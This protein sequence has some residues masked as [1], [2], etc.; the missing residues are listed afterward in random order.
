MTTNQPLA[1]T[2][3][4]VPSV[5]TPVAPPATATITPAAVA[6]DAAR[7]RKVSS[8]DRTMMYA[9][10]R[11]PLNMDRDW[12]RKMREARSGALQSGLDPELV[13]TAACMGITRLVGGVDKFQT[14][15]FENLRR[16]VS[17]HE[18]SISEVMKEMQYRI[19]KVGSEFDLTEGQASRAVIAG[20]V[21]YIDD[22][23][24]IE[25]AIG[26]ADLM[27]IAEERRCFL[28]LAVDL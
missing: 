5:N 27:G 6:A 18:V 1:Q 16:W 4:A 26:L 12:L 24:S 28:Q 19:A 17:E 9:I 10:E 11:W 8:V 23:G 22:G 21:R 14:A 25:F 3:D 13:K 7:K 20:L 15:V 2:N